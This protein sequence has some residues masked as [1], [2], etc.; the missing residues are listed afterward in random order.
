MRLDRQ[1]TIVS[2]VADLFYRP[3][4][5]KFPVVAGGTTIL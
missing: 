2:S 5:S 1:I 4:F 3:I